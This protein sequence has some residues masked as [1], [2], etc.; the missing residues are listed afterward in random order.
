M[1]NPTLHRLLANTRADEL[2][3]TG[4]RRVDWLSRRRRRAEAVPVEQAVTIR[5]AFADDA[6]AL[7]RL[8]TLDSS[9]VP[10]QP[11]LVAEVD[12]QLR[13]ALSMADRAVIADPFHPTAALVELLLA[14]ARQLTAT[15]RARV[16]RPLAPPAWRSVDG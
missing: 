13:A 7:A 2:R 10:A 11:L 8:A 1:L 16:S 5:Y 12:G 9:E 14:R 6:Y 15:A 4:A 3:G